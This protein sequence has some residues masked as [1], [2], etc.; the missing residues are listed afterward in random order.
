M[1]T[2]RFAKLVRDKIVDQQLASGVRPKYRQL[3]QDEHRRALIDKLIEEAGE[4]QQAAPDELVSEMA[5]LQQVLDDLRTICGI[6]AEQIAQAQARK[7]QQAGMFLKGVYIESVS[8][9]EANRWTAY[10]RQHADRY[11]E[12]GA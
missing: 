3:E 2:F 1:P 12:V 10:F 8:A 9:D 5:D 7:G 11:P 4:I 6:T